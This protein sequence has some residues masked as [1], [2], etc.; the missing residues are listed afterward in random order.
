M[1]RPRSASELRPELGEGRGVGVVAVDVAKQREELLERLLVHGAVVLDAVASALLQLV[2]APAG[3]G[4]P[5]HRN[6]EVSVLYE[7][8]QRREDLLVGK[9][10]GRTEEDERV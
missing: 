6:L 7:V 10:A 4:H 3:L 8:E 1:E 9:I 2:E 5:D